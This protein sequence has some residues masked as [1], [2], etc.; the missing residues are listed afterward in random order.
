[1]TASVVCFFVSYVV[2]SHNKCEWLVS[3]CMRTIPVHFDVRFRSLHYGGYCFILFVGNFIV[4]N[5][6]NPLARGC[7]C[8]SYVWVC[9]CVYLSVSPRTFCG[10]K[11][12]V[13]FSV[14]TAGVNENAGNIFKS[15]CEVSPLAIYSSYNTEIRS[16]RF[17]WVFTHYMKYIA[18]GA[19]PTVS[20]DRR[21][22][23]DPNRYIWPTLLKLSYK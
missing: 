11:P 7:A 14:Q 8:L 3:K 16:R 2:I 19:Q 13:L 22:Y 10:Q 20:N 18:A 21:T 5:R 12:C 17:R 15:F 23:H 4:V 9:V 6:L 1:M